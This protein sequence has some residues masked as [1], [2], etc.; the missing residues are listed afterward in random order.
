VLSAKSLN[1]VT[2]STTIDV[3]VPRTRR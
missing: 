2:S 1:G 3:K